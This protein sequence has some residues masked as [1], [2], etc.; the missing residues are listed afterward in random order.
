MLCFMQ[1]IL[2]LFRCVVAHRLQRIMLVKCQWTIFTLF[3]WNVQT[4]GVMAAVG[5]LP[6]YVKCLNTLVKVAIIWLILPV[7]FL[8]VCLRKI[9]WNDVISNKTGILPSDISVCFISRHLRENCWFYNCSDLQ[10]KMYHP[11][12]NG[13]KCWTPPQK[14]RYFKWADER[15]RNTQRL[16]SLK[17]SWKPLV[18]TASGAQKTG[19]EVQD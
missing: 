18:L 17:A 16:K 11:A 3:I 14:K 10:C 15:I 12:R 8:K 5:P 4:L 13:A 2:K 9:V 7:Y 6:T 1:K 19:D